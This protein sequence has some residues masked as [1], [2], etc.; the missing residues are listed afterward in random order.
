MY[1]SVQNVLPFWVRFGLALIIMKTCSTCTC[2]K[3][4]ALR[5]NPY[6][7]DEK[8]P[9]VERVLGLLVESRYLNGRAERLAEFSQPRDVAE[10]CLDLH[11][12]PFGSWLFGAFRSFGSVLFRA[13]RG[14]FFPWQKIGHGAATATGA[15]SIP[16]CQR[17]K[18]AYALSF[19]QLANSRGP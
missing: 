18:T 11:P 13:F 12:K 15:A 16:A 4:L 17:L 1:Q 3:P 5:L 2:P 9:L 6:Q 7:R 14:Q 8:L 19:T 10:I